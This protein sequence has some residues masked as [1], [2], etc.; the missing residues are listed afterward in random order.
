MDSIGSQ[1]SPLG[2]SVTGYGNDIFLHWSSNCLN[3][4]KAKLNYTFPD[5][6]WFLFWRSFSN[7]LDKTFS[8]SD[9]SLHDR[10]RSDVC[11]T[12]FGTRQ[13][14]E[15]LAFQRHNSSFQTLVYSSRA[16]AMLEHGG[17]V[18]TTAMAEQYLAQNPNKDAV[19]FRHYDDDEDNDYSVVPYKKEGVDDIL[20]AMARELERQEAEGDD[21]PQYEDVE[22]ADEGDG[23]DGGGDV[24]KAYLEG[25]VA[26]VPVQNVVAGGAKSL[27]EGE[28]EVPESYVGYSQPHNVQK[29]PTELGEGRGTGTFESPYG[30]PRTRSGGRRGQVER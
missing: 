14:A 5:C 9:V 8:L 18:N 19:A 30:A 10:S 3:N 24:A 13:T 22:V 20:A 29:S 11:R 23:G 4:A 26:P 7:N 16:N 6:E 1:S 25:E 12:L 17:A 21:L 2:L 27:S 15:L 28:K